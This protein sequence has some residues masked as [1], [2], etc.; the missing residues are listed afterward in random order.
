VISIIGYF[1]IRKNKKWMKN[2]EFK[3]VDEE[4]K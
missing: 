3:K 4:V 2:F 1:S